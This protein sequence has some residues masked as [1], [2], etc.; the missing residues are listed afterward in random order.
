MASITPDEGLEWFVEKSLNES[1][2]QDEIVYDVAV[3]SGSTSISPSDTQLDVQEHRSN[4]SDSIVNITNTSPQTGEIDVK[5]TISGGTEVPA[6]TQ[7]TEVGVWA[8][9]PSLPDSDF[10]GGSQSTNDSDDRMIHREILPGITLASGD[11]KTFAFT[12]NVVN[13]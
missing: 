13:N 6:D 12:V 7:I 9:D 2:V 11:R 8:R 1:D 3:G 4:D 5:I 10:E